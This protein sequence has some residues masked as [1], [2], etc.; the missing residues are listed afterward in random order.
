M[1]ISDTIAPID[2]LED[3]LQRFGFQVGLFHTGALCGRV[4]FDQA[5]GRGFLHFLRRGRLRVHHSVPGHPRVLELDRPSLLFYPSG[6]AHA[7]TTFDGDHGGGG[8]DA[9]HATRD[10]SS[11]EACGAGADLTCAAVHFDGGA[12]HPLVAGLPAAII[13][14]TA[15][16][17]GL[18]AALDLLFDEADQ[19][20]CGHRLLANRL[21]EVVLVQLLRWLFDN[22]AAAG[23]S[24]GLVQALSDP[25]LSRAVVAIHERPGHAWNLDALA[26]RAGMSRTAFTAAF[27]RCM[28]CSAGD[29]IA[30]YRVLSAKRELARGR[31]V[32]Q[33][34]DELGYSSP[35]AFVRMF[36]SREGTTP[37]QWV[38]RK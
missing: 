12:Q 25:R 35:T 36:R 13:L 14:P 38:M 17:Q 9:A 10:R 26:A 2:R 19:L 30:G 16:V 8:K 24:P 18:Q 28:G 32:A 34:S 7:F 27:R 20:R 37:K 1:D 3:V 21:F 5:E 29:Y 22:P 4:P 31:Q 15:E 6:A 11:A 33:V 23:V